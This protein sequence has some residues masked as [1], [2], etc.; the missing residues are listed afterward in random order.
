MSYLVPIIMTEYGLS[1]FNMGLLYAS[2]SLFGLIFDFVLTRFLSTTHYKKL[3]VATIFVA[4]AFPLCM[5]FAPGVL[6][7]IVGMVLWGLY[8]NLWAFASADFTARESK[9]IFHV[10]SVSILMFFHD[11]GYIVGTLSAERLFE[12]LTYSQLGYLLLGIVGFAL[13]MLVPAIRSK[14]REGTTQRASNLE[15]L[16]AMAK[17][18]FVAKKISPLLLLGVTA[19]TIDAVIWTVTPIIE[20][21]LPQLSELGGVILAVNFLPSFIA[22]GMTTKLTRMF[23]KKRVGTFAFILG[24]LVLSILGIVTSVPIYIM[25]SFISAFFISIAYAALGG[26][27]ADY[28]NESKSYD[29]EIIGTRDMATNFGYIIGPIIGGTLLSLLNSPILFTYIGISAAILGIIVHR[30]TPKHI[31]FRE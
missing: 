23:G 17:L 25:V 22:Y 12:H 31:P 3:F 29:N 28:I 4:A 20:T 6:P 13:I 5:F 7:F 14:R 11:V 30:I 26:A 9:V 27:Y 10:A 2:S 15:K 1:E 16:S 18:I 8:Y 24:S 19:S 21:I